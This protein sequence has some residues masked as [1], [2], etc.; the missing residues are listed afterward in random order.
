[1]ET[2]KQL[3]EYIG[4]IG[5]YHG[6]DTFIIDNTGSHPDKDKGQREYIVFVKGG[7]SFDIS[8]EYNGT[9]GEPEF[10]YFFTIRWEGPLMITSAKEALAY[11]YF[12]NEGNNHFPQKKKE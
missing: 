6:S 7:L 12:I 4:S 5:E 9:K 2:N 11:L 8:K 1:M 10:E 3:F